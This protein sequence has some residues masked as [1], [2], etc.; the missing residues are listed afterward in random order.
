MTKGE[1]KPRLTPLQVCYVVDDVAQATQFCESAL[2]WGPFNQFTAEVESASYRDWSGSKRVDV[3]LGMAGAV[4]IELMHI[5]DGEDPVA[6]FQSHYGTG[7]Q[8]LGIHCKDRDEAIAFLNSVGSPTNEVSEYPGIRFAFM[9]TP[10]G[11][12][13]FELVCPTESFA[14]SEVSGG[15]SVDSAAANSTGNTVRR[16]TIATE[17][18]VGCVNF[19]ASAFGWQDVRVDEVS[20]VFDGEEYTARR[21]RA[22]AGLLEFEFVQPAADDNSPYSQHLA[23]GG[24]GIVHAGVAMDAGSLAGQA[25][26]F[27]GAGLRGQWLDTGEAFSLHSWQGGP[28]SL[29]F[30]A[31][32]A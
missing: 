15:T 23:R 12:G 27:P 29:Q 8:H 10:T 30:Y 19:Y 20:Y 26:Q 31:A 25:A 32:A 14:S 13:M 21:T 6:T 1:N 4:Q 11:E 2:G 18:I 24:H 9:D 17:D 3:A 5:H 7:I 16:V 28:H 22:Q